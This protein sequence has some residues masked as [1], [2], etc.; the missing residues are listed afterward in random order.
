MKNTH[1][2]K[3]EIYNSNKNLEDFKKGMIHAI[4]YYNTDNDKNN[5]DFNEGYNFYKEFIYELYSRNGNKI[6]NS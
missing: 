2:K 1:K 3:I 4:R 6:Y 5:N